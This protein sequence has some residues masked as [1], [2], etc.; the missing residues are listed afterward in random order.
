MKLTKSSILV[1]NW[2]S[3]C[4]CFFLSASTA[5]TYIFTAP[6]CRTII[7]S[8]E[9]CALNA[10]YQHF[11]LMSWSISYWY[12][13]QRLY[14]ADT[15]ER[16]NRGW[17]EAQRQ[18]EERV[19]LE[20]SLISGPLLALPLWD[21]LHIDEGFGHKLARTWPNVWVTSEILCVHIYDGCSCF[22]ELHV[23]RWEVLGSINE[24]SSLPI[25]KDTIIQ[26]LV[27]YYFITIT[28]CSLLLCDTGSMSNT[29]K[30]NKVTIYAHHIYRTKLD[31]GDKSFT[32]AIYWLSKSATLMDIISIHH[33]IAEK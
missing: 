27:I 15:T 32:L 18:S 25:T 33:P 13:W 29:I 17:K 8:L 20:I 1:V 12:L 30:I 21:R 6:N 3:F 10:E 11:I 9:P 22:I 26:R 28:K 16:G 19:T 5:A 31:D 14:F 2:V 23:S 4:L 7:I 24:V